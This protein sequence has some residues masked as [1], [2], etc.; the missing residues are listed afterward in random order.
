MLNNYLKRLKFREKVGFSLN[1]MLFVMLVNTVIAA[2]T[3]ISITGLIGQLG[4]VEEAF[5]TVDQITIAE[6][7]FINTL[8]RKDANQVYQQLESVKQQLHTVSGTLGQA[9]EMESVRSL[10]DELRG[11]FQKYVIE[12]DQA[13]ALESRLDALEQSLEKQ[14]QLSTLQE[15]RSAVAQLLALSREEPGPEVTGRLASLTDLFAD[16][17][18]Q[19]GIASATLAQQQLVF[20]TVRDA[21][22]YT[23]VLSQY[24]HYRLLT[25]QTEQQLATASERV[26]QFC[27]TLEAKICQEIR[28]RVITAVSLLLALFLVSL[29]WS[30][31]MALRLTRQIA[32]PVG[33]LVAVT[34]R[35]AD[36][37]RQVRASLG[38][39][40][41]IRGLASCFND[42]A[43]GLQQSE[44]ELMA[45]NQHL[46]QRVQ[47]RTEELQ[48][49]NR[50]LTDAREQAEAATVTK[51][52]FLATMSHEIRTPMNGMIGMAQLL[53]LTDLT[54][55]Q[56][57]YVE[58]LKRSGKNLMQLINDILQLSKIEARKLEAL[59]QDFELREEISNIISLFTQHAHEKGLKLELS[60]A[61]DLPSYV[62]CDSQ[63]LRQVIMNLIGN[64]IKFTLQGGVSV[65]VTGER[66][67]GAGL[68]LRI[69]VSDTGIG[70][71]ADKQEKIF[72]P[73]TQADASTTR[74]FGG[75][76]LGLTISRELVQL[77]G[78]HIGV[79][80]RDEGQ[81]ATFWLVV[82]F[83]PLNGEVG[84]VQPSPIV[85]SLSLQTGAIEDQYRLLLVE[86]EPTNRRFV[87]AI[88][89]KVGYRVEL[90]GNGRE[91][92][93]MLQAENYDL[94]LM[95]CM[96]PVMNGYD[97]TR[98]IRD[99]AS[100]VR[101]HRVPIIAL[102][103]NAMQE[104]RERCLQAG[105]DDFLTKPL[106]IEE[107]LIAI[108]RW[109]GEQ[110]G[111]V[112]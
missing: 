59:P 111:G 55:E 4:K 16:Y 12:K 104:D 77:M 37:N 81:G 1:F 11:N 43:D 28:Q 105:M 67:E 33:E 14:L 72:E 98:A 32:E 76:G 65:Q 38:M 46:E 30:R 90:A 78:G 48:E 92:L 101:N 68:N 85:A 13:A 88:L 24:L 71:P 25:A 34:R 60:I 19:P 102:T 96:M 62:R 97:A 2:F 80:S 73:F 93:E 45:A 36:G 8:S 106:D 7:R 10:L 44:A 56:R 40:E 39:D 22:D 86:D 51:S 94:V 17:R 54:A 63:L 83:E 49:L 5:R 6:L 82:P 26:Q 27:R 58:T 18:R 99:P 89:A 74:L 3:A 21:R 50:Q 79:E 15:L 108:Q 57:E 103:A 64:A 110:R 42:L 31:F 47:K 112:A 66:A 41:E 20:A 70:I 29:L 35:F 52:R 87:S 75:T 23:G 9:R 84:L 91:A 53:A 95:D 107:L 100:V 109:I 69:T 61:D